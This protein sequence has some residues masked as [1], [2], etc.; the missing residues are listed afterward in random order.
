V[1][2]NARQGRRRHWGGGT[3]GKLR[4]LHLFGLAAAFLV[5]GAVDL[6]LASIPIS[7][8]FKYPFLCT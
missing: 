1:A 8:L 2:V 5:I 7:T 6:L 4:A 3:N